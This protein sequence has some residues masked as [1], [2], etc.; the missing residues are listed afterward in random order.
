MAEGIFIKAELKAK[1]NIN[2]III[3]PFKLMQ[4]SPFGAWAKY[5]IKYWRY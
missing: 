2:F 5:T 3:R 4:N 1:H